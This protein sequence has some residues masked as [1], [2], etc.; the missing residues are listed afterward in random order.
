MK[1]K[2]RGL[3]RQLVKQFKVQFDLNDS[4]MSAL[5]GMTRPTYERFIAGKT[6]RIT[7]NGVINCYTLSPDLIG[8]FCGEVRETDY[9]GR[10]AVEVRAE[11]K[12][13][14]RETTPVSTIRN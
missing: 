4:D 9:R 10:T 12:R 8:Y 7:L 13:I 14:C 2:T 6:D 1:V 3:E 11:I 5:F